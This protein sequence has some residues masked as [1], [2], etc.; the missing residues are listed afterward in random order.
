[1][2]SKTISDLVKEFSA[3]IFSAI[4]PLYCH[5]D[6]AEKRVAVSVLQGKMLLLANLS[7]DDRDRLIKKNMVCIEIH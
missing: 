5:G 2:T 7:E 1:V 6:E 3:A 4:L